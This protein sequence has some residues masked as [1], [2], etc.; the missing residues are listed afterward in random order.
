MQRNT[1]FLFSLYYCLKISGATAPV[2]GSLAL[3]P[4]YR[5]HQPTVKPFV[6]P[7]FLLRNAAAVRSALT[8]T[9]VRHFQSFIENVAIHVISAYR[10]CSAYEIYTCI[11]NNS[12]LI[13][14]KS[15]VA[16]QLLYQ[17]V[18]FSEADTENLERLQLPACSECRVE[19]DSWVYHAY[20][21]YG[22]GFSEGALRWFANQNSNWTSGHVR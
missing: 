19:C 22:M 21:S 20:N 9:I 16:L 6:G 2:I 5:T 17:L 3:Q 8:S 13:S 7:N 14:W 18:R 1:C 15:L 10:V 12:L 11:K 4:H